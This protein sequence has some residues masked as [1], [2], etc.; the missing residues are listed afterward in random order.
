MFYIYIISYLILVSY[1]IYEFYI[2]KNGNKMD[3]MILFIISII[4]IINSL[5]L[6]S[7]GIIGIIEKN[8]E[9]KIFD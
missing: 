3:A 8:S 2:N 6:I 4:P 7:L 5:V 1:S 9:P